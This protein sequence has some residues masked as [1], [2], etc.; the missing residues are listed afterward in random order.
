MSESFF[1][2]A[3]V[4]STHLRDFLLHRGVP[5]VLDSV[6]SPAFEHLSYLCPFVTSSAVEQV[7]DPLFF[8]GPA[9]LLY[10]RV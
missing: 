6:I 4:V 8:D 7:K 2:E 5:M 9:N 3:V 1:H 10:L